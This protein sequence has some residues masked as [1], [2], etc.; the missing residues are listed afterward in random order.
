ME[1]I[2]SQTNPI[3]RSRMGAPEKE[4][5]NIISLYLSCSYSLSSSFSLFTMYL[6]QSHWLSLFLRRSP[7]SLSHFHF[8]YHF[9]S[10]SHSHSHSHTHKSPSHSLRLYR[11]FSIYLWSL[12]LNL[13]QSLA[14][15]LA[16]SLAIF[17]ASSTAIFLY[18]FHPIY[19][20]LSLLL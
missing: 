13:S 15:Y 3:I 10:H 7:S 5:Y 2:D 14:L 8:H 18:H 17:F 1:V 20:L 11:L 16:L 4:V 9:H 6:T 19:F 12:S